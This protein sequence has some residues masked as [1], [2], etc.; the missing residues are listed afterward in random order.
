[1]LWSFVYNTIAIPLFYLAV[2]AYSLVNRKVRKGIVGRNTAFSTLPDDMERLSTGPRLWVHASSMGE[3]EQAKPIIEELKRRLPDVRVIASFFSPS[4]FEN[5]RHYE[6]ADIVTYIPF[7]SRKSARWFLDVVRPNAV[8]FIR[9]DIWPNHVVECHRRSIPVILVNAT[10]RKSSTSL[11]PGIR[12]MYRNCY[13]PM[14]AVFTV[15][16]SDAGNF[17]RFSLKDTRVEAIGDTRYDRVL[18]KAKRA[19][20]TSLIPASVYERKTVLVAGS[21]WPADEEHLLPVLEKLDRNQPG[22]LFILV[23]HEPNVEHL[24]HIEFKL[25]KKLSVIRFSALSHYAGEN[26]IL[27]DCVG[28]LL[29]L[30]AVADVAFVGGG[31]Y[32]NVH[33]VL[34][35]A[36]YGAPV[37]FGPHTGKSQEA[38]ELTNSGGAYMVRTRQ[39]LYRALRRLLSDSTHRQAIGDAARR[40]VQ[41]RG[42]TTNR[43]VDYLEELLQRNGPG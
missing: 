17:R 28:I 39:E 6:S 24:D 25:G 21:T 40:F 26:V 3:F 16:D 1:M 15:S 10:L 32:T 13:E 42:G 19:G 18:Q 20:G 9:Y 2:K 29:S 23:P 36:A 37:V 12:G 34:E 5:N 31:F 4:G 27:I 22:L 38:R 33:N 8:I 35:P 30:Y 43:I 7:D 11:W 14:G 41:Q